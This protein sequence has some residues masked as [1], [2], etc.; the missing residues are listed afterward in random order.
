[1][2]HSVQ[3]DPGFTGP[4]LCDLAPILED[5]PDPVE[6]RWTGSKQDYLV[7][8]SWAH[9]ELVLITPDVE[10]SEKTLWALGGKLPI[11]PEDLQAAKTALTSTK[12]QTWRTRVE[13]L[14]VAR[15]TLLLTTVVGDSIRAG[16][17]PAASASIAI[18][19]L[20]SRV[21]P[22]DADVLLRLRTANRQLA[23][24]HRTS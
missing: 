1:M 16:R 7:F 19:C 6:V 23:P 5:L 12:D 13:G 22:A 20:L 24:L 14:G 21:N 9:R 2:A 15:A 10:T 8:E 18:D 3:V 4:T 11:S 17:R